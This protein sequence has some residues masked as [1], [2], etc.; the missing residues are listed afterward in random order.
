[1][2]APPVE[3]PPVEL[4]PDLPLLSSSLDSL[5][6]PHETSALALASVALN[7]KSAARPR[8]TVGIRGAGVSARLSFA[9]QKGQLGSV[10]RTWRLHSGQGTR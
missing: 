4:E 3:A 6:P 2:E 7:V 10:C 5:S 8:R 1:V 9:A